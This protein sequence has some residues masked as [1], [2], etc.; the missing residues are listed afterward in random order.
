MT[1][2]AEVIWP[3]TCNAAFGNLQI[4]DMMV[5]DLYRYLHKLSH[6]INLP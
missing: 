2:K 4:I 5:R 6:I 3:I 1:L